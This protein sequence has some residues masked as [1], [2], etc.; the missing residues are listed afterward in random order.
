MSEKSGSGIRVQKT[1]NGEFYLPGGNAN[2]RAA[3]VLHEAP[4][5]T[6]N[7]RR[8]SKDLADLG[9]VVF[10]PFIHNQIAQLSNEDSHTAVKYFRE[11]PLQLRQK[12]ILSLEYLC[13]KFSLNSR[14]VAVIGYCFG[15]MAALELARS[16]VSVAGIASFHGLLDTLLP[17]SINDIKT[18]LLICTG[19][20]DAFVSQNDVINFWQEMHAAG[21]DWRLIV[22]GNASHSFTNLTAHEFED[23]RLRYDEQSDVMSWENLKEFLRYCFEN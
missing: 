16:G 3:I 10:A 8:R 6:Q 5:V 4:G 12:V 11:N 15:G 9:Y 13:E 23:E 22:F 18:P 1:W 19:A 14:Q 20:K 2:G 7:V 21:A 17:S